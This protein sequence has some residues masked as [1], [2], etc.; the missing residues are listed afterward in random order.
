MVT[1]STAC[2]AGSTRS[3]RISRAGPSWSRTTTAS[4]SA[5]PSPPPSKPRACARSGL[6]LLVLVAA[7]VAI[8]QLALAVA[9][10]LVDLLALLH[11]RLAGLGVLVELVGEALL[12]LLV[13]LIDLLGA[14]LVLAV[15]H[16][17]LVALALRNDL[18][19][20]VGAGAQA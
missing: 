7:A 19:E 18:V 11:L 17:V 10:R 13:V 1:R 6:L 5:P 9:V 2:A 20:L 8:A 12:P 4:P 3:S 14:V 16:L 15:A